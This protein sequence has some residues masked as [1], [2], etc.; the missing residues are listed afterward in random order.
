MHIKKEIKD[1]REK[2]KALK[3]EYD[4]LVESIKNAFFEHEDYWD[5]NS[6]IKPK[7]ELARMNA[8]Y[9]LAMRKAPKSGFSFDLNY[10]INQANEWKSDPKV[11]YDYFYVWDKYFEN[12]FGSTKAVLLVKKKNIKL[13]K[14]NC[15]EAWK[16]AVNESFSGSTTLGFEEWL[17]RST[18]DEILS[19][20]HSVYEGSIDVITDRKLYLKDIVII[21]PH[22]PN[23]LFY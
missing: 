21:Y 17:E 23:K 3:K 6:K 5:K 16:H 11:H 20:M 10:N 1:H 18:P 19:K 15:K 2:A 7:T 9:C 13:L 12:R 22:N 8:A 14:E 4:S